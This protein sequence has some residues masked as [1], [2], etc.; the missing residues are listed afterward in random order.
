MAMNG[1]C[2]Q[3]LMTQV[4]VNYEQVSRALST[5]SVGFAVGAVLGGIVYSLQYDRADLVT[6]IASLLSA[7]GEGQHFPVTVN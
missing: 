5:L 2:L 6:A 7:V 3:E 4:D 1:P